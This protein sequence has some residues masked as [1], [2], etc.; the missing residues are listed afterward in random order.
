MRWSFVIVILTNATGEVFGVLGRV[1]IPGEIVTSHEETDDAQ[2]QSGVR[3][4]FTPEWVSAGETVSA[5]GGVE[6]AAACRVQALIV[7]CVRP[8]RPDDTKSDD[9]NQIEYAA[10]TTQ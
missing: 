10:R 6:N 4:D 9:Q 3:D 5:Q 1:A 2:H 7:E 8:V